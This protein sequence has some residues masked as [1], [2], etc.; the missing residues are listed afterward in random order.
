M[1]GYGSLCRAGDVSYTTSVLFSRE[2]HRVLMLVILIDF[3]VDGV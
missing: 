3:N 1:G 2:Y